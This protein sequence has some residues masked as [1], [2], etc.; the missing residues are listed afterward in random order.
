MLPK[1]IVKRLVLS[2]YLFRMAKDQVEA[3]R[4]AAAFATISLL[5]DSLEYFFLAAS[6]FLNAGID[7]NTKFPQYLDKVNER[8][9]EGELPFRRRLLEINKVRVN[10]K[11]HG[12][13]PD[14]RELHGYIEDAAG[15]FQKAC[16]NIFQ[17]GFW[18]VSLLDLLDEGEAKTALEKATQNYKNSDFVGCLIECRKALFWEF[19]KRYDIRQFRHE[20]LHG[21][22]LGAFCSAPYFARNKRYIDEN[23]RD[24]FDFVVIDHSH[25]DAELAR[26]GIENSSFWNVWRLT[27]RVYLSEKGAEWLVQEDPEKFEDTGIADRSSYVLE[28]TVDVV[29][30]KT[31]Y[32]R[33]LRW[34]S[35]E[36]TDVV[37]TTTNDARV[38]AK[39]D[40]NSAVVAQLPKGVELQAK[41]KTPSLGENGLFWRVNGSAETP[42]FK[43]FVYG[44]IRVEDTDA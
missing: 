28:T 40:V 34:I 15:F 20:G 22:L 27:P 33:S 30:R 29:L 10:A 16:S 36:F 23:V 9:G 37:R 44:Y 3:Q 5:Q 42:E 26:F 12:I 41:Y 32:N 24:P 14:V 8:L 35:P 6:D 38:F 4:E 18:T 25:L 31:M 19:E 43:G 11:H 7:Q 1:N 17:I 13:R 2:R 39:A 21:G